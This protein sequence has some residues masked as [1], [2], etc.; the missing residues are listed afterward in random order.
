MVI[1]MTIGLRDGD[2]YRIV[3][4][5]HETRGYDGIQDYSA[6]S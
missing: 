2:A 5:I 6:T 1:V 3:L 4:R